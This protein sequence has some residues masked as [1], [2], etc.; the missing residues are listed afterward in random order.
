MNRDSVVKISQTAI[1]WSFILLFFLVPLIFTPYNYEL[2]EYNKMMLTYGLTA[3]IVGSFLIKSI[4]QGKIEIKRTPFDWPLL[5]FLSSQIISTIFSIDR[6]TSLFGYYSRFHGGLLSTISYIFLFY[7]FVTEFSD[8][9]QFVITS[10]KTSLISGFLVALYAVLQRL[11]IDKTIWVQDVQNR[12]FSSLGQP[13]WLAAYFAILILIALAFFLTDKSF[14]KIIYLSLGVLF[15]VVIIF[16][17][18]RSGFVGFWAG[19][20]A[21]SLL[22]SPLVVYLLG[23]FFLEI[24]TLIFYLKS[25][26]LLPSFGKIIN[27]ILYSLTLINL[28]PHFFLFT[29]K[30]KQTVK[31]LKSSTT[32][33]YLF[34]IFFI[35]TVSSFSFGTPFSQLESFTLQGI[36]NRATISKTSQ[37]TVPAQPQGSTI[38]FGGTESGAIRKIVWK[39]A[40]DIFKHYPLFGTGVETFA[41]S[42]YQFR[43]I[44]HNLNSEWDFLYNKAHNEFL[45]FAATTGLFGLSAYLLIIGSFVF[46]VGKKALK[47]PEDLPL[48]ASFL[49]AYFSIAISNFFGFSVVIIGIFFFLIPAFAFVLTNEKTKVNR[50]TVSLFQERNYLS[51]VQ[52]GNI[53]MLLLVICYMLYVLLQMWRADKYYNLGHQYVRVNQYL[54]AYQELQKAVRL[55][56][57]EPLFKDDLAV[58]SA[59]V[60]LLAKQQK[61]EELSQKLKEEALNLSS[62]LV[63]SYPK[64]V[65]FWKTRTKVLYTLSEL[66]PTLT[67]FSLEAL[68]K[69]WELAPH[70]P[71]IAYNIGILYAKLGNNDQAVKTLE[72]TIE[73]KPDYYEPHW[74]LFLIYEQLGEKEKAKAELNII[75]T[76]IRPGDKEAQKKLEEL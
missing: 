76:K 11:G 36:K 10:L 63:N 53:L 20:S 54:Q 43:P 35:L 5:L 46:W 25:V 72:K 75:L 13:N 42:Y 62:E 23:S 73:L 69:A 15:Y 64:N 44:E 3:I 22:I 57:N 55:N 19:L 12:V 65:S 58:T 31:E 26:N 1:R 32:L 50:L 28:I 7:V 61:E 59:T 38:E 18:S 27:K 8:N 29:Q 21:F 41:Y 24:I 47:K 14:R 70:D 40:L 33:K 6:H 52:K 48:L 67:N 9:K 66:D 60:S 4:A 74:A 68:A 16:T 30:R 2:F 51:N 39:G 45:N 37:P 17:K 56:P 34:L 71:K 49:G